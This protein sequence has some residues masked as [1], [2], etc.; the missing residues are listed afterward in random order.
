MVIADIFCIEF[1]V[2][3]C[4][5]KEKFADKFVQYFLLIVEVPEEFYEFLSR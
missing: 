5:R 2:G 4:L 3:I 1:F